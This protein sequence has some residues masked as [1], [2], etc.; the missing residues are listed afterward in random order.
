MNKD[1]LD[2]VLQN[3]INKFEEMNNI[4][5]NETYK[6]VAIKHFQD[7]WNMEANDFG[8]M[9][10]FAISRTENLIDGS[11]KQ[12]IAGIQRLCVL[13]PETIRKIFNILFSDDDGDLNVRQD[14]IMEF[15]SSTNSL[16]EKYE[17]RKWTLTQELRSA[18][19]YLNLGNPDMNYLYKPNEAKLFA[20]YIQYGDDFGSGR[21][22]KLEK[23]YDMCDELIEY[24]SSFPKLLE[25][26]Q[27]RLNDFTYLDKSNHILAYDIIYCASTY[28]LYNNIIRPKTDKKKEAP[29]KTREENHRQTLSIESELEIISQQIAEIE[30]TPL[31]GITVSNK[32][33]GQ[34]EIIQHSGTNILVR[35]TEGERRF[36]LPLAFTS[37]HLLLNDTRV[38]QQFYCLD[39][40]IKRESRLKAELNAA[41]IDR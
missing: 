38:L 4:V 26:H 9:F 17:P 32:S 29:K 31:L 12:P 33:Y 14:R 41:K 35:F 34:G 21:T 11:R 13:E 1:I 20:Q 6:W 39:E 18:I 40:L 37:G 25:V 23:Y 19:S 28:S 30:N 2:Q 8:S 5:N 16:L 27:G 7:H 3:Y 22:F 36:S 10:K 15:V 24:I